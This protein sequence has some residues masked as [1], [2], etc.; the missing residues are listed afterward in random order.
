[1]SITDFFTLKDLATKQGRR[2]TADDLKA[3]NYTDLLRAAIGDAGAAACSL[4]LVRAEMHERLSPWLIKITSKEALEFYRGALEGL[5]MLPDFCQIFQQQELQGVPQWGAISVRARLFFRIR[6]LRNHGDT[7]R[8]RLEDLLT[9]L[10]KGIV[11]DSQEKNLLTILTF[12]VKDLLKACEEGPVSTETIRDR[13]GGYHYL[14]RLLTP[15]ERAIC[16][17]DVVQGWGCSQKCFSPRM[18]Q[19]SSTF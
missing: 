13:T 14:L 3:M 11:G 16:M 8:V 17:N 10:E 9:D 6:C 7:P 15:Q 4:D 12:G 2:F 1:M 5:G 18:P 19:D